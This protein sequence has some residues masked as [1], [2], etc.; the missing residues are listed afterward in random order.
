MDDCCTHALLLYNAATISVLN[1]REDE[2]SSAVAD[3]TSTVGLSNWT[4][5]KAPAEGSNKKE[6]D[7]QKKYAH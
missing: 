1:I 5:A 4:K 2:L 7:Y 6:S 3:S